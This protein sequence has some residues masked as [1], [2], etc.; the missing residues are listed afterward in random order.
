MQFKIL[1]SLMSKLLPY[2]GKL[3]REKTF[4]N[5]W[6]YDFRGENFRGLLAFAV[7]KDATPQISWRKLSRIATKPQNSWKVFSRESFPLYGNNWWCQVECLLH[8]C[9]WNAVNC[10]ISL[11][12]MITSLMET[13]SWDE[14]LLHIDILLGRQIMKQKRDELKAAIERGI[15]DN[16]KAVGK[17]DDSYSWRGIWGWD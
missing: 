13:E 1:V 9:S 8:S 17:N 11:W 14:T 2:S 15:V 12:Y 5:W 4:A 10:V 7:P 16:S 6:K 3:S